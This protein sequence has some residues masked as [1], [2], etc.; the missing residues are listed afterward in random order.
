MPDNTHQTQQQHI[1]DKTKQE[2]E[3]PL[4]AAIN[5]KGG[6]DQE[7]IQLLNIFRPRRNIYPQNTVANNTKIIALEWFVVI[8]TW[9]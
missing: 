2:N 5:R 7:S 4:Q 9:I 1:I 3:A 8:P 6:N